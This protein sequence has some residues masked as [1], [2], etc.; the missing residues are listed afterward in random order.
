MKKLLTIAALASAAAAYATEVIEIGE[1]GVTKVSTTSRNTVVVTSYNELDGSGAGLMAVSNIVKT[2]TLPVGTKL[3]VLSGSAYEGYELKYVSGGSGPKYWDRD[4][5]YT[6]DGT[7]AITPAG[8]STPTE[9]PALSVGKGF[10]ISLPQA[11]SYSAD[12]IVYGKPPAV[13]NLS[14]SAGTYLVGNPRQDTAIPTVA[15]NPRMGDRALIFDGGFASTTT[16]IYTGS[17]W[18]NN[19]TLALSDDLPG[20]AAGT[21]FW[22]ISKGSSTITWKKAN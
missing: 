10:W 8:S 15:D 4:S 21:G 17:Q 2:A 13:T 14:I 1:V 19:N 9:V 22:Y 20:L 16:Y 5:N 11:E 7:G 18:R 6:V 3:Y 12:I